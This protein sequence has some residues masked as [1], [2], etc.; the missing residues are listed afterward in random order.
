MIQADHLNRQIS[1][2]MNVGKFAEADELI[3]QSIDMLSKTRG[4]IMNHKSKG[5]AHD[6]C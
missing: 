4:W 5:I 2:L 3:R 6:V 1:E